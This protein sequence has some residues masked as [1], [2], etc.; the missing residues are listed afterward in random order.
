VQRGKSPGHSVRTERARYT[1]WDFGEKGEE[2]YDH[3]TDPQEL[4]NVATDPHYAPMLAEMKT[5]LKR[6]HPVP[7]SG[8]TA[9]PRTRDKFSN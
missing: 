2:L 6:V 8:G 9:E 7:V 1:Q 4:H 5:L 3:D